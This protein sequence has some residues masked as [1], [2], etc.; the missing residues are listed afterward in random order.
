MNIHD[1]IRALVGGTRS[2][3]GTRKPAKE[4]S[5]SVTLPDTV[6]IAKPDEQ[7]EKIMV[8]AIDRVGLAFP[9]ADIRRRNY[10]LHFEPFT[11]KRRFNEFD[12]VI[13]FQGCFEKVD[14][15]R[16]SWGHR[17]SDVR[18]AKDELDKRLNE[19]KL[20]LDKD[21]YICVILCKPFVDG[22]GR[23]YRSTDIAKIL[24][25]I[26]TLGRRDHPARVP[27]VRCVRSEFA[28]F[29]KLCGACWT[30]FTCFDD[31]MELKPIAML[32]SAPAGMV[33]SDNRF[34]VP[35]L[36]P[37][38]DEN[39]IS[40]FFTLL[41]D[42]VVTSRRKLVS[43]LPEWTT[44]LLFPSEPA[45]L[46]EKM[47]AVIRIQEIEA[48]LDVYRGFRKA[49]IQGDEQLVNT[50]KE[51]LEDGFRLKVR[52]VD[53]YREDL[54]IV[55]DDGS[56]LVFCEVKGVSGGVKRE[57]INQVDSHR[58]RAG[59]PPSVPALLVCNTHIKNARSLEEKDKDVPRDQIA[60]AKRQNVLIMR[61]LDLLRL[62]RL[63][64]A[65]TLKENIIDL[66]RS[67]GWL[68]VSDEN[69]ELIG[70]RVDSAEE[71]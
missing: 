23:Q 30:T 48:S 36:I 4:R 17:Y 12:G 26:G 56:P 63:L 64:E 53:E 51:I 21:G 20:L 7:I 35:A 54:K 13:L 10:H 8:Y 46:E 45:L 11:S 38:N 49:L 9:Q 68:R 66:L 52:S 29:L 25:D 28:N 16:D 24:L 55:S 15:G 65:G 34:F 60:H 67:S 14:S 71:L 22:S 19:T 37:E 32:D 1:L 69:W 18:C 41:A 62:L 43:E 50:V 39:R 58:E 61:T 27:L 3:A 5:D 70:H 47:Q 33:L 31:G 6:N 44:N 2:E 57:F 42:A 59:M 40:E